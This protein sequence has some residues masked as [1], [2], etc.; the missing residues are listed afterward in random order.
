MQM[1][2]CGVDA[3]VLIGVCK[4]LRDKLILAVQIAPEWKVELAF[5]QKSLYVR[6]VLV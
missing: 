5:R 4:E 3:Y 6:L 1:N 2:R